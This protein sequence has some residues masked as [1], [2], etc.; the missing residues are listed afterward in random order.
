[1]G[2]EESQRVL[3]KETSLNERSSKTKVGFVCGG[4]NWVVLNQKGF[5]PCLSL[6]LVH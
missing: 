4:W 3:V 6:S 5:S 2:L 1:M